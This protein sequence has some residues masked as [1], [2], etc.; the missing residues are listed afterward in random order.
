M[1]NIFKN[2]IRVGIVSSV[3]YSSG[4][5]RVTLPDKE[6]IV[7]DELPMLSFEYNMP[8]VGDIVLCL[9][10]GNGLSNGFCLGKYYSENNHPLEAGENIFYKNLG[11][12]FC[13]YNK[14]TKTLSIS[15][16]NIV[17]EGNLRIN[18]NLK[19]DGN[20]TATG[21]ITGSNI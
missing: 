7:T 17:L 4:T 9:F 1:N 12:A 3:N 14:T 19:V 5:V 10:L 18:G 15:S 8:T 11:G 16:E 2:L 21:T 20:I 13:K 6:N